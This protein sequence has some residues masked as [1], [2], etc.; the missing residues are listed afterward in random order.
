MTAASDIGAPPPTRTYSRRSRH[1]R[2]AY[3]I[4]RRILRG[5]WA[6]GSTLPTEAELGADL[7]VSRSALREAIKM[8]AAK[9][10]VETRPK[11]GTRVRARE[12]WH[13]LDPDVLA[14]RAAAQDVEVLARELLTVR[15]VV[16]PA[17]AAIAAARASDGE[18][19]AIEAA[20]ADMAAASDDPEAA[21]VPD[22]RL[23]LAIIGA[24][25]NEFLVSL[26][27]L[28]ETAMAASIELSTSSEGAVA[29]ALP[30]HRAVVE[31]IRARDPEGARA[32]MERLLDLTEIDID[33]ATRGRGA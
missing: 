16:E 18:I 26:G 15:K 14:W 17:A 10:L 27:A 20:L 19:A 32:A 9:G 25:H 29:D 11:I 1:G 12:Q 8:L 4:G 5:D 21:V 28:T 24:T 3:E 13:M 30:A 33:R 2:V 7:G 6:P 31:A 22:V 23:H